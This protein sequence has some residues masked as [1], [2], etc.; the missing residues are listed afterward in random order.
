MISTEKG[1]APGAANGYPG[2]VSKET[3]Q[4]ARQGHKIYPYLLKVLEINRSNQVWATD[5]T[6]LPMGKGF[7]YLVAI[8]DWHSRKVLSWRLSNMMDTAFCVEALEEAIER[9]GCPE[10]FNTD[11]CAQFTSE[12]FTGTLKNMRS[13]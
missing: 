6:Y 9:Y 10:I 3:Y 7:V 8:M 5:I 12:A 11:Q 1:V 2:A 4:P 13:S